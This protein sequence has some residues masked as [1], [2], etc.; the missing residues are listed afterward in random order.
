MGWLDGGW[1]AWLSPPQSK[2]DQQRQ[3]EELDARIFPLGAEERARVTDALRRL[4]SS[5]F[6][7]PEN[8]F[9]FVAAK[10]A[11]VRKTDS[12]DGLRAGWKIL[13]LQGWLKKRDR[14]LVLA[15]I[16]L[17]SG[18]GSLEDFPA[19]AEIIHRAEEL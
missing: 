2:E 7:D 17:E 13:G 4:L 6:G 3:M 9:T 14:A 11:Y 18:I 15:L 16:E 8:L 10:E 1:P 5:K 19:D 12:E